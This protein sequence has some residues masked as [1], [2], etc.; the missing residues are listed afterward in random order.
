MVIMK[1]YFFLIIFLSVFLYGFY[2]NG[3]KVN[4]D[5]EKGHVSVKE[6]VENSIKKEPKIQEEVLRKSNKEFKYQPF[7]KEGNLKVFINNPY[8]FKYPSKYTRVHACR[9]LLD[10]IKLSKNSVDFAIYGIDNQDEFLQIFEYAKNNG[11]KLRGVSDSDEK[12]RISY[13]DMK[14]LKNKFDI[15]FDGSKYIMHN[16]FFVVDDKLVFTGSMNISKTGCG[17][18]NS[19]L[20]FAIEDKDVVFAYKNEFEQMF[21]GNFKSDKKDYSIQKKLDE[22]TEI[23][24]YFSPN[25]KIYPDLIKNEIL[26]AKNKIR[27]NIFVL[28]HKGLINDLIQAK[29]RGVEV[30]IIMDALA[31]NRYR[32]TVNYLRENNIKLKIENWGGKNHEKTISIDD[33]VLISG[34]AN[35]S[36]SGFMKNDENILVIKN[37]K[38]SEFYNSYFD[39]LYDSLDDYY[40][41]VF[42]QSESLESENSCFDG[43][44]NDFDYLID[45]NDTGCKN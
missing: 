38:I 25:E 43:I 32:D 37:K 7:L 31:S 27:S 22:N 13:Q 21:N 2:Q 30:E 20:V 15:V 26:K 45:S 5:R 36:Y 16:K 4:F 11:V 12:N 1:R 6:N 14:Q 19:N 9:F 34:S 29:K 17:G 23:G 35:F 18:Y 39:K 41:N 10:E 40:L 28:T 24:V 3:G 33:N 42:V 8:D 44:D